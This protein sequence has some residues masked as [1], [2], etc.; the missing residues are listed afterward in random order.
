MIE[1]VRSQAPPELGGHLFIDPA[2]M[3]YQ[4]GAQG[5]ALET[6]T[7]VDSRGAALA[8]LTLAGKD[9]VW[10]SPITGAFGGVAV[11]PGA[12]TEA[13]VAAVE[14]ASDWLKAQGHRATF[15]LAPDGFQDPASGA[16][17]NALFRGGWRLAQAD[18][19]YHLVAAGAEAFQ[20]GLGETKQKELRRLKRSGAAFMRLPAAAGER[21]YAVIAANRAARGFPMTMGWPQVRAL[22]EAFPDRTGFAVVE[23]DGR[24]LAGA[25]C[26]ELSADWTYVFY[27]GEDPDSRRESP[28]M[29]LAEGLVAERSVR[30]GVLDLGTSTE[31]SQPNPGLIAFKEGL[32]C[33]ASAKRTYEFGAA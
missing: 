14:A 28:V 1:V 15:R 2:F 9:G 21:A 26:L 29:L 19:N 10:A 31:E 20:A 6:F 24:A 27:W 5:K 30:G 17:E 16:V 12:G 7:A 23:R 11:Q 18:L 22:A 32:G 8:S 33:R 13:V 4:A 3:A 25:I